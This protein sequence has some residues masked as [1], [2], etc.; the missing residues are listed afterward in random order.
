MKNYY[1]LGVM[2]VYPIVA[3][4]TMIENTPFMQIKLKEKVNKERLYQAVKAALKDH[5]L[6]SCTIKYDK[7]YYLE[8]LENDFSLINASESDRPLCFGDNTDGYLWQL[9]YEGNTIIFEWCHAVS[10]GRG[11]HAFITSLLCH[12]F[13]VDIKV[14]QC[15][16][17]GLESF[18]DKNEPG[19]PQKFQEKGFAAKDLPYFKRGYKTDCH[20][21][22]APMSQVLTA[23]KRNDSS[24]AAVLPPLF[25]MA[26][27][28]HIN[29]SAKNK[30]VRCN[31]V[32][33]CRNPMKF[34]TMHNCIIPKNITYVDRFDN[35]D[36]PLVSTIY[37]AILDLAVQKE[38]IIYESTKT[39]DMIKPIISVKPRFIQKIVAKVVA[40]VM[41]H[42]DS[43]F[44]FTYLGKLNLPQ[45][46]MSN[47][48]DF[49]VRSWT[50]MGE[51]NIAAM[52]F[53]GTLILNIC[54]NYKNKQIIPDFIAVCKSVGINFELVQELP[55]EQSNLRM[56]I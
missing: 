47:I 4:R 15:F 54:E 24:P 29:P 18:Y 39:V 11:G 50:D 56:R 19:I 23:A 52:D 33:D 22:K 9:C 46:V 34:E 26:M 28:K 44:T 1:Q 13:N 48:S 12:Y 53:N 10:D 32:I 6:F 2:D 3:N 25:S 37:R 49:N 38:N 7:Y 21:L 31:V 40:G 27:R 41:K 51:C 20:I 16:N 17:L 45:E 43:N 55:F 14:K 36:F 8:P 42:T 30:N 35:M 5:P